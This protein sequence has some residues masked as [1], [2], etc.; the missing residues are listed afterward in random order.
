MWAHILFQVGVCTREDRGY[1]GRVTFFEP[2]FRWDVKRQL[3]EVAYLCAI[4]DISPDKAEETRVEKSQCVH[5]VQRLD[6]SRWSFSLEDQS[7]Q[8][9][10]EQCIV[11]GG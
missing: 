2:D 11:Q 9:F 4:Q 6:A 8:A 7:I 1:K 3:C 5:E 10:E